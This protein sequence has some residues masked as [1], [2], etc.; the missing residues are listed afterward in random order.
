MV[1]FRISKLGQNLIFDALKMTLWD[2]IIEIL[3]PKFDKK[4]GASKRSL[5][6]G[7]ARGGAS[8]LLFF[9]KNA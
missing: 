1:Q 3:T 9:G 6:S 8:K 7:V 5:G 2:Y 4:F